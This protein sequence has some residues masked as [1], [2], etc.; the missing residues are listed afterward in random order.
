VSP[1]KPSTLA[2][3]RLHRLVVGVALVALVVVGV[4]VDRPSTARGPQRIPD[5]SDTVQVGAATYARPSRTARD[6]SMPVS[7]PLATA[8][9]TWFCGGA[10]A[11]RSTIVL[12]NRAAYARQVVVTT[13]TADEHRAGRRI[14]VPAHATREVSLGFAGSTVVAAIVESRHGGVVAQQ[15]VGGP[16]TQTTAACATVSSEEW[17]FAGG[18]TQ[19]GAS[20]TLAL[21]NPFD[22]LATADVTF[23]TP[24]GFRRP[25]ATQGL[26][27][28][29]RSVVLVDV[30][31]VQNRRS[32]LGAAVTTRAGRLVAWRYQTFDG[33]GPKIGKGSPPKGVSLALG[34]ATPLTRF[35]LPTVSTGEGVQPRLLVANPGATAATVRLTFAVDDPATNGQPPPM[36]IDLLSGAV[37]EIGS[38]QLQQIPPGVAFSVSGRVVDGGA[39]VAEMWFDGAAPASGH[40]SFAAP[41]FGLSATSWVVPVGLESPGLDQ[42]GVT[43][44][45]RTARLAAWVIV[46]GERARVSLAGQAGAVP[47]NGRVTID[48]TEVLREHPGAALELTASAPVTVSRLQT[49]P[50]DRGL[51]SAPAVPIAGGLADP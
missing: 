1:R 20:E 13:V 39:V 8:S 51:V 16:D 36:T 49:G 42:L 9:T 4:V 18:D 26:A 30:A 14:G 43:S 15:R 50:D 12:T 19:R 41:A 11:N 32:D 48:L 5:E 28:P 3:G 29:G 35:S 27:V 40:G 17:F 25:Q 10:P 21:F 23:L 33:S 47:A 22:D 45:G 34:S 7:A 2:P 24:D 44:A 37:Q 46:D 38:D 31:E 6:R